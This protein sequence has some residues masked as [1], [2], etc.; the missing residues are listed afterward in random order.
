MRAA[1]RAG[2]VGLGRGRGK[3]VLKTGGWRGS[4]WVASH[5]KKAV[6]QLGSAR[7]SDPGSSRWLGHN[8]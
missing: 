5:M 8:R 6:G 4:S 3:S 1:G 2:W 7:V